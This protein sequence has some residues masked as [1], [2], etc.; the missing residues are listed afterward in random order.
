MYFLSTFIKWKNGPD[1]N[2][3]TSSYVISS[4]ME[5]W[6]RTKR[7]LMKKYTVLVTEQFVRDRRMVLHAQSESDLE[8]RVSEMTEAEGRRLD[9]DESQVVEVFILDE[10]TV[11]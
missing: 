10:K 9:A 2:S 1:I 4:F 11:L 5:F 7:I 8:L 3:D 6:W